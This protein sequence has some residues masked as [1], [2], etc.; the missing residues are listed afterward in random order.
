MHKLDFVTC[1]IIQEEK[2][3]TTSCFSKELGQTF[4]TRGALRGDI[5]SGSYRKFGSE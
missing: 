4:A 2:A 5:F 3:T 1:P